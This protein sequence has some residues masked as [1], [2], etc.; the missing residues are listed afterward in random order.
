MSDYHSEPTRPLTPKEKYFV[1]EAEKHN[2]DVLYD[3]DGCPFVMG[4]DKC[5]ALFDSD[6]IE[7]P[8]FDEGEAIYRLYS[9]K[10]GSCQEDHEP[11]VL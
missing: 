7:T 2:F 9:C 3:C 8:D 6:T 10:R 1:D 5:N 11:F 4:I